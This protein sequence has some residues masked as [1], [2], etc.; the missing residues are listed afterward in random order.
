MGCEDGQE[1]SPAGQTFLLRYLEL[2]W[3]NPLEIQCRTP[4]AREGIAANTA[5]PPCFHPRHPGSRIPRLK[6]PRFPDG[7]GGR[8]GPPL[9]PPGALRGSHGRPRG[10]PPGGEAGGEAG[11]FPAARAGTG[12]GGYQPGCWA[13]P[14]PALLVRPVAS[15]RRGAPGSP[16]A[17]PEGSGAPRPVGPA[18]FCTLSSSDGDPRVS[19][20]LKPA[21]RLLLEGA[22]MEGVCGPTQGGSQQ[23]HSKAWVPHSGAKRADNA[24]DTHHPPTPKCEGAN[25]GGGGHPTGDR[26]SVTEGSGPP[27]A[28]GAALRGQPPLGSV[29]GGGGQPGGRSGEHHR[30]RWG[31]YLPAPR[32]GRVVLG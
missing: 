23:R 28:P 14:P 16:A 2:K 29:L 12:A 7:V 30:G 5:P 6:E 11:G 22:E 1:K 17:R 31:P 25:L 3:V 27:R 32:V 15:R 18:G 19:G 13:T 10:R 21:A 26:T 20:R 9:Q 4:P 24:P 8:E